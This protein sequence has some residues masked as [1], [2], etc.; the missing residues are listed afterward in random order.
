MT[1][2]P[3][4]ARSFKCFLGFV[5]VG[6]TFSESMERASEN[7]RKQLDSYVE[8]TRRAGARQSDATLAT[9]FALQDNVTSDKGGNGTGAVVSG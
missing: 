8:K 2:D 7:T 6:V 9:V 4:N 3:N 5:S 1:K